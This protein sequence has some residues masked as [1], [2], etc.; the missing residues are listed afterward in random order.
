MEATNDEENMGV[1]EDVNNIGAIE[2]FIG[3]GAAECDDTSVV[4]SEYCTSVGTI[5]N[6][7]VGL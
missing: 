5:V 6:E 3:M 7:E 1:I 4:A 2:D